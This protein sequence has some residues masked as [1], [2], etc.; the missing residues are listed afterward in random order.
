MYVEERKPTLKDWGKLAIGLFVI[1][2]FV[3][4]IAP[5]LQRLPPIQEVHNHIQHHNIDAS[6]LVYTESE[7]FGDADVSIRDAMNY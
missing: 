1:Y 7:E 4:W 5:F 6:A 2:L 3:F